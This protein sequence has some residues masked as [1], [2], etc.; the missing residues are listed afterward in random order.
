M[1]RRRG[2]EIDRTIRADCPGAE[3]I[4]IR[5]AE[6]C[7]GLQA[8]R[9]RIE[10]RGKE[11][12]SRVVGILRGRGRRAGIRGLK[13][14]GGDRE[15]HGI[16]GARDC[17]FPFRRESQEARRVVDGARQ[18]SDELQRTRRRKLVDRHVRAGDGC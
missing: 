11:V 13:G 4:R 1:E 16:G 5:T 15:I 9:R 3:N 7:G 10:D 8:S 18:V 12:A 6:E 2:Q 17:H 14:A